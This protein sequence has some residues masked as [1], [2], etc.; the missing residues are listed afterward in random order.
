[1]NHPTDIG[2]S[3]GAASA[4]ERARE[5]LLDEARQLQ[6]A[7]ARAEAGLIDVVVRAVANAVAHPEIELA[8]ADPRATDADYAARSAVLGLSLE[9]GL[10]QDQVHT[11]LD[12]GRTLR[13]LLP[14]TWSAFGEGTIT[15]QKARVIL[16]HFRRLP[17]DE[18]IQLFFDDTMATAAQTVNVKQ[19]R[20]KAARLADRLTERPIEVVHAEAAK[21]RRVWVDVEEGTGMAYFTAYLHADEALMAKKRI[22]AIAATL[23]DS[24]LPKAERR[25]ADQK[26]ADVAADILI[27]KG[28]P[29]EVR[30]VVSL[31]VPLLNLAGC[32]DEVRPASI[33]GIVPIPEKRARE[34]VG[35]SPSLTRIF[36]DPVD[37]A[38]LGVGRKKYVPSADLKRFVIARDEICATPGCVR[39]GNDCDLDHRVDFAKG[40]ETNADNLTPRCP[41]DHTIKH[42][43]RWQVSTRETSAGIT[44]V[45]TSPGGRRYWD[46]SL[47]PPPRP[48]RAH[49]EYP[50]EVP[51]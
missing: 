9:L 48:K 31:Y 49:V 29:S 36:T 34:L 22:T 12:E 50:D 38:V 18:E 37:G 5:R 46:R 47:D 42:V 51:F 25:S 43:T 8:P 35:R 32:P 20:R 45:W 7:Q 2:A 16:I 4:A 10:S 30:P 3:D 13:N 23:D 44:E 39:A 41:K 17:V 15:G 26:R 21:A 11:M 33:D 6:T 19:L 24:H 28:E 1:M 14:A 27:G 40:G